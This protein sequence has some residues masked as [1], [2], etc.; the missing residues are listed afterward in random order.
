[1]SAVVTFPL[2]CWPGR[3]E[4]CQTPRAWVVF[5]NREEFKKP[6]DPLSSVYIGTCSAHLL[7]ALRYDPL[8]VNYVLPLVQEAQS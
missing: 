3:S 2:P 7:Q 6:F 8:A 1:M 5:H 4:N